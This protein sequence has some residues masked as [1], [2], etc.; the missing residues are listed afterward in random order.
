MAHPLEILAIFLIMSFHATKVFNT[1]EGGAIMCHDEETKQHIDQLKNFG[2]TGEITVIAPGINAKMNEF[3]AA[4]G[5]LQLKYL[6]VA[7]LKRKAITEIY[8]E[9]LGPVPGVSFLTDMWNQLVIIMLIFRSGLI[10]ESTV[11]PEM[12][13]TKN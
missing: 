10:R 8:R 7:I 4:L 3:Q 2:F 11:E 12:N 1:F 9:Y 13:Y 6:N 5:I